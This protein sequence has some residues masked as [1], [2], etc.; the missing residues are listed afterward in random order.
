M[1]LTR[2]RIKYGVITVLI[3]LVVIQFFHPKKNLS[4]D[5]TND[6]SK[7]FPVPD[8]VLQI[9]KTSCY[10]CHSNHTDYPWYSKIEPVDWWLTSHINDGKRG[11]NFNE[12]SS[13]RVAK[14]YKRLA[15][16]N[17]LVEKRDMPLTSYTLIHRYA[18]LSDMQISSVKQWANALRDTI[19]ASYPADSLVLPKRPGRK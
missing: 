15:D 19:K 12:F 2:Q 5:L 14:Q 18:I 7:K 16:I 10:D 8:S 1:I 9:L 3:A 11:L 4:G 6:I 17:E 13:Y